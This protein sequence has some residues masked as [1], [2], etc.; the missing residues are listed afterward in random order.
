MREVQ[1]EQGPR[2]IATCCVT[3]AK[4]LDSPNQPGGGRPANALHMYSDT[5]SMKHV[6]S[7]GGKQYKLFISGAWLHQPSPEIPPGHPG[8]VSRRQQSLIS[9]PSPS[10]AQVACSDQKA[11]GCGAGVQGHACLA[12]PPLVLVHLPRNLTEFYLHQAQGWAL[13]CR[14]G[15]RVH[16]ISG[17]TLIMPTRR[18]PGFQQL[19]THLR[20]LAQPVP[21]A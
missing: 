4:N 2:V 9:C 16:C 1:L 12:T 18:R 19:A 7:L 13:G 11:N 3:L 17:A 6:L 21:S 8:R 10:G 14:T 15:N 20:C 5:G